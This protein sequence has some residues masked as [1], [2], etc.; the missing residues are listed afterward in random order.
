M[1]VLSECGRLTM[2]DIVANV[3]EK[4][5]LLK[6]TEDYMDEVDNDEIRIKI[7]R[8]IETMIK[9]RFLC[10]VPKVD[11]SFPPLKN[12]KAPPLFKPNPKPSKNL[13]ASKKKRKLEEV[14]DKQE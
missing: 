7:K 4:I 1:E 9:E 12:S 6:S 2:N 8:I 14:D 3:H 11:Q 10:R 5:N 13:S